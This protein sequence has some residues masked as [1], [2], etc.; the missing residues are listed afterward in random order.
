MD[1]TR[2]H[3]DTHAEDGEEPA[4]KYE[5]LTDELKTEINECFD[6]FDKDKDGQI[7]Y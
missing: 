6:I 1:D 7:N 4:E 2:H 5:L 3:N